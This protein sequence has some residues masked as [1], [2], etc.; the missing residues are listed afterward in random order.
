MVFT[1]N[2]A[3]TVQGNG[4][5]WWGFPGIGYLERL[6]NRPKLFRMDNMSTSVLLEKWHFFQSPYWTVSVEVHGLEIRDC[7]IVN[8]R[9]PRARD[10][11][12]YEMTAF[13]TDGFDVR[14]RNIWI[15][16][17]RV[18][19]QDDT[20]CVKDNTQDVL[21]EHVTA[22]GV[23][24]TIGSIA[25]HVRNVTFRNLRMKRT[26]MGIYMKFRGPGLIEDVLYENIVMEGVER[27][28]VWIG[29]AQ[30]SDSKE[31]C[32]ARPCSICWPLLPGANCYSVADATFRNVMLRNITIASPFGYAGVILGNGGS[33]MKNI[34]FEDVLVI[35]PKMWNRDYLRCKGV[36][37]GVATGNTYPVPYC[38]KD[39]TTRKGG[40]AAVTSI[41]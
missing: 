3:G 34:T 21:I 30:Q 11:N 33:P 27:Y 20:F 9:S 22:S 15:H 16:H 12:I 32:A 35:K 5:W 36:E 2:G 25:S 38:F 28:G 23:G 39:L 26:Y 8:R 24:L 4:R 1:S 37:S 18:W 6:E 19:N 7:S 41:H 14:G 17:C 40:V 29:P 31:I 13:N 10:H